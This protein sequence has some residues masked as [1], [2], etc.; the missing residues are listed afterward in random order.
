M[1][2]DAAGNESPRSAGMSITIDTVAPTVTINQALGQSDPARYSPINFTAQFSEPIALLTS[3]GA[4]L[5]GTAGATRSSITGNG[6]TYNVAVSGMTANGTVIAALPAAAA[7]DFAGNPSTAS[8]ST[9]NLVA[10][11]A[12]TFVWSGNGA[13]NKWTTAANWLGGAAPT[14]GV[15]LIFPAGAAQMECVNDYPPD[16]QFCSIVV[17]GGDY[18]FQNNSMKAATI[19]VP[20]NAVLTA[21]SIVSDTLT[22]GAASTMTWTGGGADNRWSTAAN[23]LGGIAPV[24]GDKLDF[25]PGK[26]QMDCINDYPSSVQFGS[27]VVSGGYHIQNNAVKAET[28]EVKSNAVF[29]AVS[30]ECDTLIIGSPS[31]STAKAVVKNTADVAI[32]SLV[33]VPKSAPS[34]VTAQ[35]PIDEAPSALPDIDNTADRAL[36][37]ITE[38]NAGTLVQSSANSVPVKTDESISAEIST[39]TPQK[40]RSI[41]ARLNYQ[42]ANLLFRQPPTLKSNL[43]NDAIADALAHVLA[44][45]KRHAF[46]LAKANQ[47]A[48]SYALQSIMTEFE[49]PPADV[50]DT[51]ATDILPVLSSPLARRLRS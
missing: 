18:R 20:R 2:R 22:I 24:S 39:F 19:E 37:M 14:P 5:S 11:N 41:A 7:N 40:P 25:P 23:W 36:P 10:Y 26:L 44:K 32:T 4:T 8:T 29:T 43:P 50:Q 38:A 47:N 6:K 13:D 15:N 42:N 17:F 35:Q 34:Q 3:G 1:A 49:H 31:G 21:V 30:I 33:E 51:S 48:L 28:I 16:V 27:I 9:D 46:L 45:A 12:T